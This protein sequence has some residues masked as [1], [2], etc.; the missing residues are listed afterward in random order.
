MY[1][2]MLAMSNNGSSQMVSS[3]NGTIEL[4]M[5]PDNFTVNWKS[6]L[7]DPTKYTEVNCGFKP[8]SVAILPLSAVEG[9]SRQIQSTIF[10]FDED[11]GYPTG[12]YFLKDGDYYCGNT[13]IAVKFT[14]TGFRV[15]GGYYVRGKNAVYLATK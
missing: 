6:S 3:S 4:G 7:D 8:K 15:S 14:D 11:E 9:A 2:D 13:S 5:G 10:I 1:Q 12:T